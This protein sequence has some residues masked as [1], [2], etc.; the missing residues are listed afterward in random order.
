M[1]YSI[2]FAA[3]RF[4]LSR[5]V[6]QIIAH[7]NIESYMRHESVESKTHGEMVTILLDGETEQQDQMKL[8]QLLVDY[9]V[10]TSGTLRI[11]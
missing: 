10:L 6:K 5:M 4:P 3:G 7:Q 9:P 1:M 2:T 8:R 11:E